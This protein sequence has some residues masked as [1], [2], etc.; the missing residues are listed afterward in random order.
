MK[1]KI[2]VKDRKTA[3]RILRIVKVTAIEGELDQARL[4]ALIRHYLPDVK[5]ILQ[6]EVK[7]EN[8]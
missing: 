3:V 6:K 1:V 5:V 8:E 7:A 4:G 2:E